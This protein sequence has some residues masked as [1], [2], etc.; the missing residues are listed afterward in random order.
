MFLLVSIVS[1]VVVPVLVNKTTETHLNWLKP[2]LRQV[3]CVIALVY[4][5]YFLT[6]DTGKE[7]LIA[8]QS[9][10][11]FKHPVL[12]IGLSLLLGGVIAP[13]YWWLMGKLMPANT[14]TGT[15][16]VE[17]A[18]KNSKLIIHSALYGNGPT[19]D[20]NVTDRLESAARDALVIP[21][22]NNFLGCDPAPNQEKRL[23][24][25]Y[26]YGNQT[27]FTV[28]QPEYSRLVLPEDSRIYAL[29]NIAQDHKG[30]RVLA[31]LPIYRQ[32]L[33]IQLLGMCVGTTITGPATI[34]LKLKVWAKQDINL[35]RVNASVFFTDGKHDATVLT[36]LS[37]WLLSEEFY[38]H[39]FRTNN[40]RELPLESADLS[41]V[42]EI[43]SGIFREG[44]HSAKWLGC[45]VDSHSFPREQQI[46]GV[47]V[48]FLDKTGVAKSEKFMHP[49]PPT[50]YR[51]I[52]AAFRRQ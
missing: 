15:G 30:A 37:D 22:D 45:E 28:S 31:T 16:S 5:I 6:T 47:K 50:T 42:K 26:S 21:V 25:E 4:V 35:L 39:R 19:N 8:T 2:Y 27:K 12:T 3:W 13:S 52:D 1:L 44:H 14:E 41:F 23:L 46:L 11:G 24:V 20:R 51:I 48:S 29:S 36:S 18:D 9:S 33:E 32:D 38:D 49:W 7:L 34:F 43:E 40:R 17:S 10:F